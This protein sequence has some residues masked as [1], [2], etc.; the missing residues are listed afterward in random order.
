MST[1]SVPA[2]ADFS[3]NASHEDL[4]AYTPSREQVS[5]KCL[6]HK[7]IPWLTLNVKSQ[8]TATS[9]SQ[10]LPLYKK[11]GPVVTG[12]IVL[13][14]DKPE[15]VQAVKISLRG[16]SSFASGE[17]SASTDSSPTLA[18][19]HTFV[20]VTETL[21]SSL[22]G[23]GPRFAEPPPWGFPK[24]GKLQG[25]Y[26]F[27][28]TLRLPHEFAS[29]SPRPKDAPAY[30]RMPASFYNKKSPA[31]IDYEVYVTLVRSALKAN[32]SSVF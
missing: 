9:G 11:P 2:R 28:F 25:K 7:G 6:C 20:E 22:E 3:P 10:R 18:H 14:L 13:M 30:Y 24:N 29:E 16:T 8:Y 27:P 26:T 31:A 5:S 21:W 15:A 12:D 32:T 17:T 1:L 23:A 4:P 19:T